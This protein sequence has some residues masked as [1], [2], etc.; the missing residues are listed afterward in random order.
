M[1]TLITLILFTSITCG[2]SQIKDIDSLSSVL[3]FQKQDSAKVNT[4]I[5]IIKALYETE[6]YDIAL[7]HIIESERL[8]TE[9]NYI[10]GLTETIYHKAL[11]HTKKNNYTNAI[12]EYNK[13]KIL[14]T[15]L[16]DTLG[17]ANVNNSIGLIEI[18]KENYLKGIQHCL[19]AIK[20]LENNDN[21]KKTLLP[22]YTSL[23]KAYYH[24]GM[25][26]NAI[27]F[28]LKTL[29][30]QRKLK[31]EK[32]QNITHV[33]LANLYAIKN[34]HQKAITHYENVLKIVKKQDTLRAY[35]YP[36]LGGEY[37]KVNNFN[38]AEKSLITG[39]NLNRK[40]KNNGNY[41]TALNNLAHLN[42]HK[43]RLKIVKKQF[44][45]IE[46]IAKK[47]DNKKE[48]LKYYQLR[49]TLDSINQNF[50]KAF[51]W[52]NKY[53]T[54]KNSINKAHAIKSLNLKNSIEASNIDNQFINDSIN[55][56][57]FKSNN[58]ISK[59]NSP[60]IT[61]NRAAL[62]Q[63]EE[64]QKDNTILYSLIAALIVISSLFIF[65]YFVQKKHIKYAQELEKKNT[66]IKLQ[67]KAFIEKINQL[68]NTNHVKNKLFS[69]VSH[70][71]KDALASINGFFDL[72]KE[73][74]LSKKEFNKLVPKTSEDATNASLLLHNLLNWAKSQLQSL[75]PKPS[76]FN[77]Q[78]VF[79]EKIKFFDRRMKNKGIILKNNS[80]PDFTYADQSMF[81]II[82]QNLLANALKFCK[83][84][85]TITISNSSNEDNNCIVSITD[86]GIG[87]SEENIDKLFNDSNFS[88][89]G[90]HNEKGTG[91][92][93]SICKELITLN[94]G[95]IWVESKL[96]EGSSF[97]IKLP[98]SQVVT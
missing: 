98:K 80:Q 13:A 26:D 15:S 97:H 90:T 73:D 93:L 74:S 77:V 61:Q 64:A 56:V 70:D 5:K 66:K 81:E 30:I 46:T 78:E 14:Y 54:L 36:K 85:D 62:E 32:A 10:E 18:K 31:E 29:E 27:M 44:T 72:L 38:A 6:E 52:Q 7:K 39:Y 22:T 40:A 94:N 28:N 55:A 76:I 17:V 11:I 50:E 4:S 96:N 87:I 60:L 12:S 95:E 51:V 2:F 75:E 63:Q 69:I 43:N 86:T 89:D 3:A 83:E 84:G 53:H 16:D 45:E 21:S 88:T 20:V 47:T 91:L 19:F 23:A 8:S 57:N 34:E 65:M 67:N 41:L 68:E 58:T 79:I 42:S 49:K 1:K 33:K 24:V 35:I 92:G 71:L 25:Y 37:L 82:I 48:L 9:L 59:E